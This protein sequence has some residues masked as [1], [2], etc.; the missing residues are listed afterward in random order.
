MPTSFEYC[1]LE[2]TYHAIT[3]ECGKYP[4]CA[5]HDGHYES[6]RDFPL[7]CP[8]E[9]EEEKA[10]KR[11]DMDSHLEECLL[12]PVDCPFQEVGCT[13]H[14]VRKDLQAHVDSSDHHHLMLMMTAF[15]ELK[16]ELKE[17]KN[18]TTYMMYSEMVPEAC[19]ALL[20][21]FLEVPY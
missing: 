4:F 12:Q 10:I 5:V 18:P 7:E 8:N 6:C 16:K 17:T 20:C 13:T 9:C 21:C 3:G 2:D 15:K 11:K 14:V 19:T 1:G